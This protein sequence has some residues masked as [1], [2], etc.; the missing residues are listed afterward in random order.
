[1]A[2]DG[3]RNLNGPAAKDD[4]EREKKD[5]MMKQYEKNADANDNGLDIEYIRCCREI[6]QLQAE[7]DSTNERK[8]TI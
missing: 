8:R 6:E 1:M 4:R 7:L 3:K 5:K 2:A